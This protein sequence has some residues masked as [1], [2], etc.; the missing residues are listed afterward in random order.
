MNRTF[1][2]IIIATL[3]TTSA[4]HAFSADMPLLTYPPHTAVPVADQSCVDLTTLTDTACPA[5]EK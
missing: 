1:P 2:A 4:G 3:L 5:A